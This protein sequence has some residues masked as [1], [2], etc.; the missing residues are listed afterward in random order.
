MR[1]EERVLCALSHEEPD[2]I[3]LYDLVS[4]RAF[5]EYWGG[6]ALT[7]GNANTLIHRRL[8]GRLI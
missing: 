5:I 8:T 1:K 3:P 2:R 4:S 6:Q 7:L